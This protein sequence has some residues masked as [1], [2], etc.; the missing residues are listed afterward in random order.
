M[1]VQRYRANIMLNV[2]EAKL[3]INARACVC[4]RNRSDHY[5]KCP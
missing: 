4:T 3:K 1:M 2:S 5:S